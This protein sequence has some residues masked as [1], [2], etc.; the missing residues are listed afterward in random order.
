[1]QLIIGNRR[2]SSWSLR[3]H[4]LADLTG[5]PFDVRQA[6]L[7]T[8]DFEALRAEQ[9]PARTV[10]MM[11][12][13]ERDPGGAGFC[14]DS[15]AIAEELADRFPGAP[16]WP[17]APAARAAARSLAAEMHAGFHALRGDCPMN[18]GRVY[19]GFV[20]SQAVR[21]DLARIEALWAWARGT[22][23]GAGPYLFGAAPCAA[24]AM[25]APVASRLATYGLPRSDAAQAYV[26]TIF[27]WGAFR[28]WRAMAEPET[29]RLAD[30]EKDLPEGPRFGP[31]PRP[32]RAVAEAEAEGREAVNAACP[33]SGRPVAA[34]SLAEI[35]GR[36]IGFCNPFCRDK[37]V[38]DADAWPKLVPLLP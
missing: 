12:F 28:R 14:W 21:D 37:S 1:M 31:V 35:D 5:A 2:Y 18:L 7:E 10:P 30:S 34:N 27:A 17:E 23:G 29:A 9:T 4:L 32:A 38:A 19:A 16:I 22:F 24:D 25:F 15:L 33:Y 26:E 36:V 13:S 11:R 8:P 6:M 3:G 20:P